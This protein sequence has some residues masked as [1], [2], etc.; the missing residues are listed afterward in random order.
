VLAQK[1]SASRPVAVKCDRQ[2]DTQQHYNEQVS[3][4]TIQRTLTRSIIVRPLQ[5]VYEIATVNRHS[6]NESGSY[7]EGT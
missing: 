3:Q 2:T 6:G 5:C 4:P 7:Y 1:S